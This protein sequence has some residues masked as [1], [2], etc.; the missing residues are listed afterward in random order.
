[1]VTYNAL[2]CDCGMV[3]ETRRAFDVGAGMLRQA[4]WPSMVNYNALINAG[5]KG[6][7]AALG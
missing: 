1:M 4:L 7:V 2:I 5:E 3:K 6:S